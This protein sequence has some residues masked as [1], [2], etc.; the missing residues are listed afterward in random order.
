[1]LINYISDRDTGTDEK[2]IE[3]RCFSYPH[4]NY[5]DFTYNT[6]YSVKPFRI[7]LK[8]KKFAFLKLVIRNNKID[9]KLTVNSISI[10]KAIGGNVK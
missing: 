2:E 4:W 3:N 6:N 10:Q 7:K 5:A 9:E 1:M 8:A